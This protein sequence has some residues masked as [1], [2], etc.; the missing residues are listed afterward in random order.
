MYGVVIIAMYIMTYFQTIP[1]CKCSDVVIFVKFMISHTDNYLSVIL[2][3]PIPKRV[4]D[5][6]LVTKITDVS[7]QHKNVS[8]HWQGVMLDK[9]SV[10]SKL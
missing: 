6:T 3:D 10:F 7:C 4:F 9:T 1:V 2:G 5:V 8:C